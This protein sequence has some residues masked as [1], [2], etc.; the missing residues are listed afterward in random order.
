MVPKGYK[1]KK[2]FCIATYSFTNSD[3]GQNNWAHLRLGMHYLATDDPSKAIV[4]LQSVLRTDANNLNA[5]ES[6]ADAYFN[7]GSYTSALKAYDKVLQLHKAWTSLFVDGI[8]IRPKLS[9]LSPKN[10]KLASHTKM[11]PV[12]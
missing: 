3:Q 12:Y 8:L 7:R 11:F 9:Q 10:K 5:W 2:I 6:L 1:C 4:C